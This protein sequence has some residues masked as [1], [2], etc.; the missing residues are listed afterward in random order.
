LAQKLTKQTKEQLESIGVRELFGSEDDG[1]MSEQEHDVDMELKHLE[2]SGKA[3]SDLLYC[4]HKR[5]NQFMASQLAK[6]TEML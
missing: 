3:S 6:L 2:L 4:K 5:K 1:S